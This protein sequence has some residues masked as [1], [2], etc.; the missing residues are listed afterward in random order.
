MNNEDANIIDN[1]GVGSFFIFRNSI[2]I[3]FSAF[4]Y[5]GNDQ[6]F[7]FRSFTSYI[8]VK[9]DGSKNLFETF[10]SIYNFIARCAISGTYLN[11]L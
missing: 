5:Y 11:T 7:I 2:K 6:I 8:T 10:Y 9:F 3:P 4:G 1:L